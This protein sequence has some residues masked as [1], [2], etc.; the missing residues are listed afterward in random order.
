MDLFFAQTFQKALLE[1][2][3]ADN[4]NWEDAIKR[5][6]RIGAEALKVERVSVWLYDRRQTAITCECLYVTSAGEHEKGIKLQS[7]NYPL[8]FKA[9]E[10]NRTVAAGDARTD[11]RTAEFTRNYLIPLGI[12]SMMDV[13]IRLHGK[14]IGVVC[15]EHTGPQRDWTLEDQEFGGSLADFVSLAYE[16]ARRKQ[17]ESRLVRLKK[18]EAENRK[19]RQELNKLKRKKSRG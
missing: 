17:A 11:P 16:A 7:K 13:P 4:T 14:V 10:E 6:T 8:Y 18:V 2:T 15:H 12:V 19:L 3:K 1:L 9:L 5:I